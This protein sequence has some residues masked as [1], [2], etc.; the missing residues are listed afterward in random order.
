MEILKTV[1]TVLFA[2]IAIASVVS[3]IAKEYKNA[4]FIFAIWKRFR[5]RMLF[6][7]IGVIVLVVMTYVLLVVFFPFLNWGWSDL[8]I[9]GGGN[10]YVAPV[11]AVSEQSSNWFMKALPFLFLIMFLVAV[12]FLA[13]M[14]EKWFRYGHE[15]WSEIIPQSIKFGLIHLVVGIPI[16]TGIALIISGLFFGYKYKK[17]F[18]KNIGVMSYSEASDEALMV[19][20]TYHSFYNTFLVVALLVLSTIF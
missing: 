11:M 20:T 6:E 4:N 8:F 3:T 14:E 13:R 12:P 17:A 16:A 19:S 2:I 15:E 5:F 1:L 9:E 10:I 7:T 18:D